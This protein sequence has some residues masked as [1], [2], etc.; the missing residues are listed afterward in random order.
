M[1]AISESKL[2]ED[3]QKKKPRDFYLLAGEDPFKL[4]YYTDALYR[5][6]FPEGGGLRE[7]IYAD[8]LKAAELL[9]QVRTPSL[10][11]PMKF[12]LVRQAERLVAK[13]WETLLPLL[14]EPIERCV[15][16]FQSAKADARLKFFQSLSKAGDRAVLVKLEDAVGGEWNL[17]L[18]SFLKEAGKDMD[19]D[20]RD[21]LAE[22]TAGSLSDLKHMVER[23]ALFAGGAP[24]ITREHV[25]AVGFRIAPEDVFR[26]TG[27]LLAGDRSGS[28]LLLENLL[29]QGEEPLAL[30][31]LLSRQYRWLLSI[32]TLRAEGKADTAI[33]AA[34]GI[35]PAAGKVLFPAARRLGSKG[36]IRGLSAL[37]ET[38]HGLKSSRLPKDQLLTGLVMRL[39]ES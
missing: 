16:V 19:Q 13:Q 36:V 39:T 33:A 35:F 30:V 25:Q 18:Q 6:V 21:V 27:S 38:D 24:S 29:R 4:D 1:A 12:I 32:L 5:A 11:D 23:A 31:G 10:W 15:V 28:L 2:K 7:I 8:E 22:W 34:A 20:A 3:A 17:W 37:A 14:Q 9:D 26:F